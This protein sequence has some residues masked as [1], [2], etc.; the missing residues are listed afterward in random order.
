MPSVPEKVKGGEMEY[1]RARLV[2]AELLLGY[3]VVDVTMVVLVKVSAV[4][5]ISTIPS[6]IKSVPL[7][8]YKEEDPAV[9]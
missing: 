9:N 4:D 5:G 8:M 6:A 3:G 2:S 7:A 1:T